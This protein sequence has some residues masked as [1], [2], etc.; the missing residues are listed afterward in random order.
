MEAKN[1]FYAAVGA[2][3]VAA[4]KVGSQVEAL[5]DRFSAE[6]N[7]YTKAAEK[8][9]SD[10]VAEGEKLV[11]KISDGKVVEEISSKVDLDQA[12][13]QV[14]KLRDQLE[15]MISTWRQSFRPDKGEDD[16]ETKAPA[17]K[18][19]AKTSAAK[20]PAAKKPAAKKPAAKK[21]AAKTSAAKTTKSTS[22]AKKSTAKTASASKA[23]SG[24]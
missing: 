16:V 9:M 5:K 6:R 7:S 24:S 22:A 10:W 8:A 13:E 19:A 12:K 4:R 20:K 21:P 1:V 23:K 11:E 18:P 14:G 17:S 3:V 2:P 15:D